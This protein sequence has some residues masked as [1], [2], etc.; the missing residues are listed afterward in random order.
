[1][2]T[3]TKVKAFISTILLA[4]AM[5]TYSPLSLATILPASHSTVTTSASPTLTEHKQIIDQ[6]IDQLRTI[7]N[8]TYLLVQLAL[9]NPIQNVSAFKTNLNLVNSD[10]AIL[11]RN[12]LDYQTTILPTSFQYR[13]V[14]LLLNALNHTKNALFELEL[15]SAATSNVERARLLENLFRSRAEGIETLNMLENLISELYD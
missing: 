14:L 2:K 8:R 4:S 3:I 15:L 12:V 1:M 7:Q 13:D 9:D 11:R 10:A 6:F 5:I